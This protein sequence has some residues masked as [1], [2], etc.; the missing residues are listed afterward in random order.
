MSVEWTKEMAEEFLANSSPD[1]MFPCHSE[2]NLKEA[3]V[4]ELKRARTTFTLR[5]IA[6]QYI[7]AIKRDEFG[8]CTGMP[9]GRSPSGGACANCNC[10]MLFNQLECVK[11]DLE[12]TKVVLQVTANERGE[13]MEELYSVKRALEDS[14]KERNEEKR[15]FSATIATMVQSEMSDVRTQLEC[16]K[17]DLETTKVVLQ[18]TANERGEAMEELYSVK[19]A[20]EEC[21]K[22]LNEEKRKFSA[23]I[24]TMVQS[25]MSDVRTQLDEIRGGYRACPQ[26]EMPE[27]ATSEAAKA[28]LSASKFI[29]LRLLMF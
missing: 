14:K 21:K 18:V 23:T 15:K 12:T 28:A 22:E 19:R 16:V 27:L 5:P 1:P 29:K 13:A 6:E 26:D 2:E 24:A 3:C 9:C 11:A 7:L 4:R 8:R 10:R 20:L 17:A 25:E